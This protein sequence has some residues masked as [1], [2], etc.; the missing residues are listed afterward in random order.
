[1][2]GNC[3][4]NPP[5]KHPANFQ[6]FLAKLFPKSFKERRLFEKRRHP[7]TFIYF[8]NTLPRHCPFQTRSTSDVKI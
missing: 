2:P 7:K 4:K 8:I 1:M 5:K 3:S 6:R